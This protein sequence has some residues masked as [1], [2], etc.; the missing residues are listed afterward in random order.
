VKHMIVRFVGDP[1][2]YR[3]SESDS[4]R[5]KNWLKTLT[6]D[7]AYE[8]FKEF[9]YRGN[10]LAEEYADHAPTVTLEN[11]AIR[12]MYAHVV[13][14]AQSFHTILG[15]IEEIAGEGISHSQMGNT[16]GT[17]DALDSILGLAKYRGR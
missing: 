10:E 13:K 2:G 3:V 4:W 16:G 9:Y 6:Q 14:K 11:Y 17:F 7:E 8:A 12:A 1:S 5:I 15:Q